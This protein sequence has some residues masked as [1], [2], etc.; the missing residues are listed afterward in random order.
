MY[1]FRR[2]LFIL[3]LDVVDRLCSVVVALAMH[4]VHYSVSMRLLYVY[5]WPSMTPTERI[6]KQTILNMY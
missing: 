6:N 5:K 3:P 2:S 1:T 4:L